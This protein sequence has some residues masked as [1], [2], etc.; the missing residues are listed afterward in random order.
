MGPQDVAFEDVAVIADSGL[1]LRCRVNG[2]EVW[3]GKLQL[4]PGSTVDGVGGRGRL[5]LKRWMLADLGLES[6]DA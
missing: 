5:V 2:H 6:P 1:A 4:Q 3:I